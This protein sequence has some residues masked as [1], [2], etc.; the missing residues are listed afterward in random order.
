MLQLFGHAKGG[1]QTLWLVNDQWDSKE[2]LMLER[3]DKALIQGDILI[4][5]IKQS[6][7]KLPKWSFQF[8]AFLFDRN[9]AHKIQSCHSLP[10]VQQR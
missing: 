5:I 3:H 8:M 4:Q 7:K 2:K 9:S 1:S 10:W 6:R